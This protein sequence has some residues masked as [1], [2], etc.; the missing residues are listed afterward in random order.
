MFSI[1]LF[2]QQPADYS[3]N[4]KA[5]LSFEKR[6]LTNSALQEAKKIFDLATASGNQPQ[7]VKAAMYQMK[8]RNMKEEDNKENN[9]FYLDTLIAKTKSPGKQILQSMQ[10]DLFLHIAYKTGIAYITGQN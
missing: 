7:Q 8:Y 9:I 3:T 10:A 2:A 6:G 4:W 5:V 1:K